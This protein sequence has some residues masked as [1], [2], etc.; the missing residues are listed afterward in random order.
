MDDICQSLFVF[1]IEKLRGLYE[2]FTPCMFLT[3]RTNSTYLYL[4]TV[5]HT[6][7]IGYKYFADDIVLKNSLYYSKIKSIN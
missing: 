2:T 1:K 7:G 6:V 4:F 5:R 3:C